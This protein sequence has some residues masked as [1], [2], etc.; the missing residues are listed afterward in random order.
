MNEYNMLEHCP[1]FPNILD[2]WIHETYYFLYDALR[3]TRIQL[4]DELSSA[5]FGDS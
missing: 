2:F 5:P 4:D 3:G 1:C